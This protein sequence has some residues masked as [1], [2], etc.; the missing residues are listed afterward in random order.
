MLMLVIGLTGGIGTGK[1]SVSRFLVEMGARIIDADTIGHDLYL[2][3]SPAWREIVKYF[4]KSVIAGD[5]KIDRRRLGDLIFNS[6]GDREKLNSIMVPRMSGIF[7]K[8]IIGLEQK[9]E[10][11][12]VLEAAILIESGW[13][14]LVDEIWMVQ[15]P[16][17]MVLKRFEGK[18]GLSCKEI[19]KRIESQISSDERMQNAQVVINNTGS[20]KE[21]R[22]KVEKLWDCKITGEDY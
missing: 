6:P 10:R 22:V 11:V 15:A 18:G 13:D 19:T 9:H 20:L 17:E 3:Y 21:L 16:R 7:Q 14:S 2:P 8:L 12:V 1:S 5:D 4:G